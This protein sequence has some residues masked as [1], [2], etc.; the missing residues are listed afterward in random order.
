[1]ELTTYVRR[2]ALFRRVAN[3][4]LLTCMLCNVRA[5][6][7]I[8]AARDS[9]TVRKMITGFFRSQASVKEIFSTALSPDGTQLC[10]NA[11]SGTGP[12]IWVGS[13][14]G[15]YPAHRLLTGRKGAQT[16][17]QWSPDGKQIAFFFDPASKG[18]PEL[19]V[20]DAKTGHLQRNSAV[21]SL[22]GF[23]SRLRWSPDGASLSFLY[24]TNAS[25]EPS[26]MA[27]ENRAV[28]L[29][30]TDD[31]RDL[32]QLVVVN[33]R[34]RKLETVSPPGLYVFEYDWKP[35]HSGFVYT[36]AEPPG[37]DNWYIARLYSQKLTGDTFRLYTPENQIAVPR[38][39]PDGSRIAFIEGLMSDQGGT[40]GEIFL[41]TPD[42]NT[43]PRNITPAR[44]TTPSWFQW[45]ND[46]T[47]LVSEFSG[48]AVAITRLSVTGSEQPLWKG[49]VTLNAGSETMSLSLAGDQMAFVQS[50]WNQLPEVYAGVPEKFRKITGFND[51]RPKPTVRAENIIWTSD[52]Q[53]VQGW[54]L[55][56]EP[57]DPTLTYPMLVAVHGG[58]AWISTP[59]WSTADFNTTV[60]PRL[61]YF[62]FFPNPRGSYGQGEAF[63]KANRKDWGF[64]DLSDISRGIDSICQ[65][66][67][68]DSTRLGILGWSYGG[69]MAM[70]SP[71]RSGKF[72]ASV[73]GAG[74]G[75][76]LSYYGQNRIDK[77]MNGYF[78]ISPYQD[79]AP[80]QR[81]S[82]MTYIK[83][84][85]TPTLILVGE[86]D[87]ESPSPQSF[88]YWHA[89]KELGVPTQL[90]VYP[91]EGHAFQNFDNMIDVSFRTIQ[92]FNHYL[93]PF[94]GSIGLR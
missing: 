50:G 35:D 26:P 77:W 48:G 63:T 46:S 17:P 3:V 7:A 65:R 9:A 60:Y 19:M 91:D 6:P 69:S 40:G 90:M 4:I 23:V 30:G 89:L 49:D 43:A 13:S 24:V 44:C 76:W 21:L 82:A 62:V 14:I 92:W 54:L 84:A 2:D 83:A 36:A 1:M 86:R 59:G 88:Q 47:L 25:R 16:E 66:L 33:L 79:P 57:Y 67:P 10:W 81:V 42:G 45:M 72:K 18:K 61:G 27:A 68:V 29:I 73:A 71:L 75:D 15:S 11:D 51:A 32:Q 20:A 41:L 56:P 80:Y 34:T 74:A 64:G 52:G 87:G 8:R 12:A 39:S 37:D 58:P 53:P 38:Y 22:N 28:G 55:Y 93:R 94:G 70:I 78:G 31:R 85:A 5:Q